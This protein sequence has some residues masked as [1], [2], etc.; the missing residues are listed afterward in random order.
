MNDDYIVKLG[1]VRKTFGD[2]M[3]FDD[4][5]FGIKRRETV[6]ICGDSGSG[7]TTLVNVIGLLEQPT[8][9]RIF[10]NGKSVINQKMSYVAKL[11]SEM[12]G[13]IFQ[14]CNLILELNVIE[15]L[16]FPRRIA[17]KI[18]SGDVAF[19]KKLLNQ[20]KLD[21]FEER[22]VSTLSGGERQRVAAIRAMMNNPRVIIA[23]E[24]TGSLDE[25]SA[26][27]VM[28]MIINLCDTYD[29]SL[30]LITHN[31][32]FAQKMQTAYVLSNCTLTRVE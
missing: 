11:R 27:L 32:R 20:V 28:D 24:P 12:F 9:G 31:P 14:R 4:V 26:N 13:Y 10:W 30:L 5:S 16:L 8:H 3:V 29:S 15:N 7:K 23:D 25:K 19:A 6:S 18:D 22:N 1:N 17:D 21:G 2:F